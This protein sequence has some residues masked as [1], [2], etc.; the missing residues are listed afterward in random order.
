MNIAL[1][2]DSHNNW[3]A[4]TSAV[5]SDAAETCDVALF[6]GD[7]TRPKGV[8]ILADFPGPVHMIVG[9]MDS[10]IDGIW[11]NAEDTDNVIYHGDVCNIERSG[12]RIYMQH[13]PRS[14]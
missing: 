8:S 5:S 4:L 13:R 3:N 1:F 9:N 2:S 10:N 6:A 11:A 7:L 12:L 14:V